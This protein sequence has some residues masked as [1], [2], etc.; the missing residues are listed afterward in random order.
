MLKVEPKAH[1]TL[2]AAMHVLCHHRSVLS[3]NLALVNLVLVNLVP[4]VLLMNWTLARFPLR[5]ASRRQL[6]VLLAT[7]GQTLP[8]SVEAV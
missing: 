4:V 8:L 1:R 5:P 6:F 3:V 7:F 2:A